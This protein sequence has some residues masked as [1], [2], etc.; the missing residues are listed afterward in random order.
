MSLGDH[1]KVYPTPGLGTAF[2]RIAAGDNMDTPRY[3][4]MSGNASETKCVSAQRGKCIDIKLSTDRASLPVVL[5]TR[6]V[7][8][9]GRNKTKK[10]HNIFFRTTFVPS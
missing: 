3:L 10:E 9:V 5:K 2:L 8:D 6:N 4:E 1:A 7:H